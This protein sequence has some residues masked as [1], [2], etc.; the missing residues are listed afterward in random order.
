MVPRD[1]EPVENSRNLPTN[2]LH[3]TGG[4]TARTGRSD[5]NQLM[6]HSD[7]IDSRCSRHVSRA[8]SRRS[9]N[10]V[11]G[12]GVLASIVALASAAS[13]APPTPHVVKSWSVTPSPVALDTSDGRVFT[14]DRSSRIGL[15]VFEALAVPSTPGVRVAL[16][17]RPTGIAY[18]RSINFEPATSLHRVD[19]HVY[20]TTGANNAEM[21]AV[22]V[23]P[24][25]QPVVDHVVDLPGSAD[26]SAI[27]TS[28]GLLVVG[29]RRSAEH[30]LVVL[31]PA[32]STLGGLDLPQSINAVEA[33]GGLVRASSTRWTFIVDVSDPAQPTLLGTVPRDASPLPPVGVART[34]DFVFD[35]PSAYLATRQRGADLQAV[36]LDLPFT[37]PDRDGDG[38][39]RLGCLGDSNTEP[40]ITL[41]RWCEKLAMLVND[42]RFEVVNFAVVG[43]TAIPSDNDATTQVQSALDPDLHLDAAVLAYG[44]NDTNLAFFSP[45]PALFDSQ[46][47]TIADAIAQH[48]ATLSAAGLSV[49]V[50]TTPPRWKALFGPDGYN[51]RI[52]A[53]NDEVRARFS[54]TALIEFYDGFHPDQSE[55]LDGVHLSQGGQDKRAWRALRMLRR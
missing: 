3:E 8:C 15:T 42:S 32:G 46:I 40:S 2:Q 24:G 1:P 39:W 45:D 16:P 26:A 30:E 28:D 18:L 48:A 22:S 44:T 7:Q 12:I 47:A 6:H 52:V 13:A 35:G 34:T 14:V 54:D 9:S 25:E 20:I 38:A 29:R 55:I 53:L 31:Q 19:E 33:S 41:T 27:A 4:S 23:Q 51:D 36:D 49:Y 10:R 43:A 21:V 11:V 17:R 5:R 50:A 37:F